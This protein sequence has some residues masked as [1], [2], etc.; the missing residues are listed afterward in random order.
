[1]ITTVWNKLAT[2]SSFYCFSDEKLEGYRSA[3]S[4]CTKD[5]GVPV[6]SMGWEADL[7]LPSALAHRWDF[8]QSHTVVPNSAINLAGKSLHIQL[9]ISYQCF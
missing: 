7:M 2:Q 1:M 5:Q 8:A 3:V 6:V 4:S 9:P